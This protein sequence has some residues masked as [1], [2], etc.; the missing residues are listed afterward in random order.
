MGQRGFSVNPARAN[1]FQMVG[2]HFNP[3]R[4]L[5]RALDEEMGAHRT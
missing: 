3:N 1:P 5:A 4:T 2:I